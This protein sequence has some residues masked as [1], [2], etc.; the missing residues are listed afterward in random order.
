MAEFMMIHNLRDPS[1]PEGRTY[2]EVNLAKSHAIPVGAL[3]EFLSYDRYAGV[4]L[5]VVAHLRD[6]DGTPL[7]AMSA[8]RLDTTVERP[9]FANPKWVHG[10]PESYLRVVEA[11]R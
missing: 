3:V 6:C 9:G 7:Y 8:D 2:R 4:R 1:D 5:Y 10:W 11:G